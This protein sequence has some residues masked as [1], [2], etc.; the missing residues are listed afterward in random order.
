MLVLLK[1][2]KLQ[3]VANPIINLGKKGLHTGLNLAH[4]ETGLAAPFLNPLARYGHKQIDNIPQI[5]EGFGMDILKAIG[6][7]VLDFGVNIAK[8]KLAGKGVRKGKGF[9]PKGHGLS[10]I[11]GGALYPSGYGLYGAHKIPR[12]G[13]KKG[14]GTFG[15]ILG[16]LLGNILPF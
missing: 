7:H 6:P 15:N 12:K 10:E 4:A 5:G 14:K 16:S 1:K 9:K 2:H 13:K 11:N 8:N 3:G